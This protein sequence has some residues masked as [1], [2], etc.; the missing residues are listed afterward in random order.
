MIKRPIWNERLE[1]AWQ[2][3][4][5]VWLAGVRR[6]GKTVLARELPD[7]EFLNCD[8][9]SESWR[10]EDPEA[11]FKS[12]SKP[13]VVLDEVHQLPDPSRILKIATDA[14]PHLHVL[15]T[16]SSTL[17]ASRKF[18]DTLTG[19]KRVV[20][21]TPVLAEELEAFGIADAEAR[22]LRGGLP[23]AL[24]QT[25]APNWEFYSE[26][27]DSY[28]ARDV[29]ELFH[30]GKRTEFL[31]ML[32]LVLRQSGGLLEITSLAKHTGASRP[33]IMNWL[34][35]LQTTQVARFVRPFSGGGRREIIAQPKLYAFDTGF[36]CHARG[37][38]RLRPEDLGT[39]WE[40]LVLDTLIAAPTR[41]IMFW[42]D[43]SQREI[44]F[45]IPQSRNVAD[46]IECKWAPAAFDPENLTAFRAIY[47]TG[48]NVV[49][50]PNLTKAYQKHF[51]DLLV[52]FMGPR[53]LRLSVQ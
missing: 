32:E 30:V 23:P 28:F 31:R 25:G 26:W 43:K 37:W 35:V 2:Q 46:A 9:P 45:I 10:L 40:H 11:F 44:D 48:R 47:P 4:P 24:L 42:R 6:A 50:C 13:L 49:C 15:A 22:I 12:V 36:V 3:V 1:R 51:G 29:Q 16:G 52:E 18:R 39:L 20:A 27:L 34:D 8:L 7:A 21:L 38:D 33:T 14:F 53:D 17:A 41:E 19:R 5:L